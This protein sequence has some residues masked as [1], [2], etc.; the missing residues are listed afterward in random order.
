MRIIRKEKIDVRKFMEEIKANRTNRSFNSMDQRSQRPLEQ[1]PDMR[2]RPCDNFS[3]TSV[4]QG[5]QFQRPNQENYQNYAGFSQMSQNSQ[6]YGSNQI[7]PQYP[8][9]HPQPYP[10]SHPQP[11]PYYSYGQPQ[12]NPGPYPI[13][14]SVSFSSHPYPP[15]FSQGERSLQSKPEKKER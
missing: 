10:Q 1:P 4:G 9:P 8:Q 14:S 3:K 6:V 2:V 13:T 7:V 15:Q 11:Q 12:Y 5:L